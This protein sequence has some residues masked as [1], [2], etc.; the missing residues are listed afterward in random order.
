MVNMKKTISTI[1]SILI[2]F[3]V[4]LCFLLNTFI[5]WIYL[6]AISYI[7]DDDL[8]KYLVEGYISYIERLYNGI[9]LKTK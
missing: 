6:S 8:R 5:E 7:T 3:F 9:K 1:I 2:T 4:I